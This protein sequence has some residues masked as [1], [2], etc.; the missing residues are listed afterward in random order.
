MI[1]ALESYVILGIR[2]TIPFL[3]DVLRSPEF[4]DGNTHTGLIDQRF[5]GWSQSMEDSHLA[6]IAYVVE[7]IAS[8]IKP[9]KKV[10]EKGWPS[11]SE[12]LGGW[13]L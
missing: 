5:E 7:E 13:R 11:P 12:T 9:S 10:K 6:R 1:R 3:I 4:V 2:T 8:S